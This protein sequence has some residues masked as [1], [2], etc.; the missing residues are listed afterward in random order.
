M[1]Q[2]LRRYLDGIRYRFPAR[3]FPVLGRFMLKYATREA[4]QK[5][6]KCGPIKVLV[7]NTVLDVAVTHE[8]KWITTDVMQIGDHE[9]H[10]GHLARVPVHAINNDS[11]R[12]R[13]TT[14]LTGLT[15]L[16]KLGHIAFFTSAELKDEQFRQ[17]M[18]RYRGYGL[19][20][21][22]L[23]AS[24]PMPSLD[25]SYLRRLA[26]EVPFFQAQVSNN[27]PASALAA[28]SCL[29]NCTQ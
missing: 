29:M 18:G 1:L 5:L 16:A 3:L 21:R 20:D 19:F 7:D 12:Y 15:H 10:S 8:T 17:P 24:L 11:D 6:S 14:F 23:F 4:V 2:Q 26:R 13:E 28:I 22:S 25:G 9:H 27:Q